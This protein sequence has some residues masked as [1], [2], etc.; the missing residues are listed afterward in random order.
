MTDGIIQKVFNRHTMKF[1]NN[2]AIALHDLYKELITEIIK[3]A[4]IQFYTDKNGTWSYNEEEELV[5]QNFCFELVGDDE[6]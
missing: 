6:K 2:H 4:D 5:R 1:T 3:L